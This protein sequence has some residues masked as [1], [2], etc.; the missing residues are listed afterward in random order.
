MDA[1]V[2]EEVNHFVYDVA[3]SDTIQV[4]F[5]DLVFSVE[6]VEVGIRIWFLGNEFE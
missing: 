4:A 1:V 2:Q 5:P 3:L 6:L